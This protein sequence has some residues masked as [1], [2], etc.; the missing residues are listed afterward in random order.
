[1]VSV[2]VTWGGIHDRPSSSAEKPDAI[3]N[4]EDLHAPPLK[5]SRSGGHRAARRAR[6]TPLSPRPR[7]SEI[8][9][10]EYTYYD[11]SS[12]GRATRARR[13]DSNAALGAPRRTQFQKV[14]STDALGSSKVPT[15]ERWR[16]WTRRVQALCRRGRLRHRAED[17]RASINLI[18]EERLRARRDASDGAG[19]RRKAEPEDDQGDSRCGCSSAKGDLRLLEVPARSISASGLQRVNE[20]LVAEG[21]SPP[22]S[23][24]RGRGSLARRSSITAQRPSRSGSRAACADG[25]PVEGHGTR[26]M[27]A[28][29]RVPEQPVAERHESVASSGSVPPVGRSSASSRLRDRRLVIKVDSF[30]HS[31]AWGAQRAPAWPAPTSGPMTRRRG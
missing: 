1:M 20:R 21:R 23:A 14:E 16:K 30:E 13:A 2:A 31:G 4:A 3:S 5:P 15:D 8:S 18:Y 24:Q 26:S 27:A 17:R 29:P 11:G 25:L 7:R 19:W 28:R 9:D 12:P 6:L 22:E 10:A